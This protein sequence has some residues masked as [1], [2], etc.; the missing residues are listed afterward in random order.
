MLLSRP[1]AAAERYNHRKRPYKN[2]LGNVGAF[3]PDSR[4]CRQPRTLTSSGRDAR[5]N[6]V[7]FRQGGRPCVK[8]TSID[9]EPV[10]GLGAPGARLNASLKR[11]LRLKESGVRQ[12]SNCAGDVLDDIIIP[13][14]EVSG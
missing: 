10:L 2:S 13:T 3:R 8:D 1:S 14:V 9:V 7:R 12:A 5:R 4:A 11:G 6:L